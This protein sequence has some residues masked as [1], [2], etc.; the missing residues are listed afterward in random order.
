[1]KVYFYHTQ[2]IQRIVR[3]C[4]EGRFPAHF[5]YGA[6][7]LPDHDIHP[8]YHRHKAF[9]SRWRMMLHNAWQI[10]TCSEHYDALYATHYR[11]IEIVVLLRA[12]GLFRRPIVIW[13]HQP[14]V[15]PKSLPRRFLG[16]LFYRGFDAMFFF[17]QKLI[18]DSLATPNARPE[19]MFLGHW[20]GDTDFYERLQREQEVTSRHG[21]VST[22]KE[23][24]DMKTLVKAFNAAGADID[25]YLPY[26]PQ[27]A[28]DYKS[29]IGGLDVRPN[30]HV[31]YVNGLIPYELGCIVNRAACVVICCEETKYT[32][33]LT[34]VVEAL[35]L[36]LPIV[37]S[38]NPQ[39]PVDVDSEGCGISVPYYDV[40]GWVK[41]VK[42]IE[43][44]PEEARQMGRRARELALTR[45]NNKIC[46][47]EVAAVLKSVCH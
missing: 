15:V 5:L 21:F 3:E 47:A 44:H 40:D 13:H 20:G 1:M 29:L 24:R 46:A 41:A 35:C 4:A 8:V 11:G 38:R 25:I 16:R 39:F 10:L 27:G 2:D 32:V 26:E 23:R 36:G 6:T 9:T 43:E 28:L 30:V 7:A 37:C 34:T 22:G 12:I 45:F 42:Y 19:R 17:S 31:N 33:G 18:N 14:M